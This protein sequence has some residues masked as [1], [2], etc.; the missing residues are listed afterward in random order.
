MF[1]TRVDCSS[2]LGITVAVL[3]DFEKWK[4]Q[5]EGKAYKLITYR[6]WS[7][8]MLFESTHCSQYN[9]RSGD[10][11]LCDIIYHTSWDIL[12]R[13][14][15]SGR[16]VC[17]IVVSKEKIN[18]NDTRDNFFMSFLSR[19]KKNDRTNPDERHGGGKNVDYTKRA[20]HINK[21]V[22]ADTRC[23]GLVRLLPWRRSST[24]KIPPLIRVTAGVADAIAV[25]VADIATEAV[26]LI[27]CHEGYQGHRRVAFFPF[28]Q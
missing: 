27:R 8:S 5:L 4:E 23:R 13:L 10:S 1:L 21:L 12:R 6:Q 17:Q 25:A 16:S 26:G 7:K 22:F 19:T 20:I 3:K 11:E 28:G 18:S 24:T 9:D 15:L 14:G 2:Y